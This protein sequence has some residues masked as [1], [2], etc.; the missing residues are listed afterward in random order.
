VQLEPPKAAPPPGQR[1]GGFCRL[2]RA[3][4]RAEGC[5]TAVVTEEL[6]ARYRAGE[7]DFHNQHF[8]AGN[9]HDVSYDSCNFSD[10]I[11]AGTHLF[12]AWFMNC[13]L[14]RSKWVRA[15]PRRTVF[16]CCKMEAASFFRASVEDCVLEACSAAR[17]SFAGSTILECRFIK[18]NFREAQFWEATLRRSSLKD[19]D[20]SGAQLGDT[21][22][23]DCDITGAVDA[24]Y[25]NFD[26][27]ITA[28][29]LTVCR[30]LRS[31]GLED[32]LLRGGMPEVFTRYTVDCARS[33]DPKLM[34]SLMR[35]T[36]ISYGGPD[37]TFAIGLR[38][39]LVRNGVRT[40]LFVTDA[41]AGESL[42]SAMRQGVETHDRVILVC[43]GASLVRPGVQNEIELTLAKEA[44]HGGALYLIPVLL[45]D[46]LFRWTPS[47]PDLAIALRD[48]V[49]ADFRA[50]GDNVTSTFEAGVTRLLKA[51][52]R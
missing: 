51:L 17:A 7:R 5:Y 37:T 26:G 20:F 2:V 36:F 10:A 38:D 1:T 25:I 14:T 35:S 39:A 4:R 6:R 50:A 21:V 34:F 27:Q 29:W 28:D 31:I 48:R 43:S 52:R 24:P 12:D 47:R 40:F 23:I 49:A 45:D 42:H 44:R 11:F 30:S 19:S 22:F 46:Y 33:M 8:D 18:C 3:V 15:R 13:D 16:Q 9:F 32:F 41:V